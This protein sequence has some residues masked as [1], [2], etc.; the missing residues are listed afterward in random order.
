MGLIRLDGLS[1]AL[2]NHSPGLRNRPDRVRR[3]PRAAKRYPRLR[4]GRT[5]LERYRRAWDFNE[6]FVIMVF[7]AIVGVM[8]IVRAI[9]I[10]LS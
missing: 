6:G 4:V 10:I 2:R 5:R 7:A 9:R 8:G 1:G 3:D